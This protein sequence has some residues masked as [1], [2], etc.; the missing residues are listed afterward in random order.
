[1]TRMLVLS[2][3]VLLMAAPTFLADESPEDDPDVAFDVEPPPLIQNRGDE[4]L[5]VASS[6]PADVDPAHLER[7]LDRAKK[8]ESSADRLRKI[9]ALSKVEV[10]QRALRV[11]RLES[12]LANVRLDLAKEE[13]ALQQNRLA[14]GE[15]SRAELTQ[16]E[17]AL[18]HAIASAQIA[19]ANLQRAELE[20]A[21]AN[22]H[23]QEK[24]LVMGS[25]RKSDVNRAEERLA[26][27]KTH[28][29]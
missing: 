3:A 29:N 26:E 13:L 9:G 2:A 24:L 6:E 8:R 5:A 11:V 15:I 1:M 22:L 21:E 7:E 20:A 12:N 16:A 23:R 27:L 17:A 14:A 19:A 4:T 18:A 25:A 28:Q 10:E